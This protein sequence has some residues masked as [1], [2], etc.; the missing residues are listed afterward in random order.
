MIKIHACQRNKQFMRKLEHY[1]FPVR[2]KRER[3][4]ELNL[5]QKE[6]GKV[7]F[8]RNQ[9]IARVFLHA[10]C[11]GKLL[12]KESSYMSQFNKVCKV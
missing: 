5:S 2:K 1:D 6:V 9:K 7:L 3:K 11:D 12:K 8:K 10:F 4:K